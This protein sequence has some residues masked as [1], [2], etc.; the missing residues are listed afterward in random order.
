MT[1]HT[2]NSQAN[3]ENKLEFPYLNTIPYKVMIDKNLC[4]NAKLHFGCLVALSRKFGYCFASDKELAKMHEIDI[5]QITRWHKSLEDQKHILRVTNNISYRN[6]D[7]KLLWK[8]DRKIYI[9]LG[10]SNNNYDRGKNITIDDRD[11]NVPS[12]K[13]ETFK[14]K[15]EKEKEKEKTADKSTLASADAHPPDKYKIKL[16]NQ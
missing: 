11:K 8:K 1:H 9:D 2:I 14:N 12:L 10:F 6:K 13:E 3:Q 7:G 5:R 15:K 4:P 16:T